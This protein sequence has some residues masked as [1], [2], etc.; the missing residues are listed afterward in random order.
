MLFISLFSNFEDFKLCLQSMLTP[1]PHILKYKLIAFSL[2]QS[3]TWYIQINLKSKLS[4]INYCIQIISNVN[5][6]HL[7]H[8]I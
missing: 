7:N 3:K 6:L 2:H 8:F 5:F 1:L 4:K